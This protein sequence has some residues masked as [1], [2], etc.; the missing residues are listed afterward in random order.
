MNATQRNLL[1]KLHDTLGDVKSEL[2]S[3]QEEETEKFDNLSEGLQ[4]SERG[5]A[6]QAA[7]DALAEAAS[8]I[9]E[10]MGSVEE[11]MQ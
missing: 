6:M 4:A 9:E 11:A 10:A 8:S 7:A 2:E 5:Q 1:Q 3:M